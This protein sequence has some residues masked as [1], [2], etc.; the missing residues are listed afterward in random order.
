MQIT[1]S[2]FGFSHGAMEADYVFDLRFLP[3]PFYDEKMRNMTGLDQPVIDYVLN[4]PAR[5]PST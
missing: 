3:N 4:S 1:V 5:P 2:S